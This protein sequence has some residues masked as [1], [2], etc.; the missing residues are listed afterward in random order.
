[1]NP[2][3]TPYLSLLLA[4]PL[5]AQDAKPAP[6]PD[7]H[8]AVA[9]VKLSL[10]QALAIA[11]ATQPGT[12]VQAELEVEE[13]AGRPVV[14]FECMILDGHGQAFEVVVDPDSGQAKTKPA[15]EPEAELA[16]MRSCAAK[17]K[18]TLA[19]M[20]ADAGK[21]VRGHAF[22]A[23]LTMDEDEVVAQL[24]FAT[25]DHA[26]HV[27]FDAEDGEL[28]QIKA[29][30]LDRKAKRHQDGRSGHGQHA[31]E[32]EDERHEGTAG[33]P[34]KSERKEA[35]GKDD[36]QPSKQSDSTQEPRR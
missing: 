14:F 18:R 27:T 29:K 17:A 21:L 4:V 24:Q 13:D 31:A 36:K 1:M 10:P 34:T 11:L 28:E 2:Y 26:I 23:Q 3:V 32:S 22:L 33:K 7:A 16:A 19:A 15:A 9:A 5:C 35:K 20:L 8:R 30:P 6:L 25:E 12:V